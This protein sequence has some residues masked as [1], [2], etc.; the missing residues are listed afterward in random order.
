MKEK[1]VIVLEHGIPVPPTLRGQQS[2]IYPWKEMNIGDSFLFPKGV[3]LKSASGS[4]NKACRRY[5]MK[6]IVR[7]YGDGI[8]CWRVEG[9]RA[10]PRQQWKAQHRAQRPV[11]NPDEFPDDMT[12]RLGNCIR[13]AGFKTWGEVL[14]ADWSEW[15]WLRLPNLG[16]GTLNELRVLLEAAGARMRQGSREQSYADHPD[17]LTDRFAATDAAI[18]DI[19]ND[20]LD[21]HS[22]LPLFK[23]V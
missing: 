21:P 10:A 22:F 9:V 20:N 2:T 4:A 7:S 3:S 1:P 13:A 15:D 11:T 12:V 6:F 16:R 19:V 18:A 17:I 14:A 5:R 23:K 8:R